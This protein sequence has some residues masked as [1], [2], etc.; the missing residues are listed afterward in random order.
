MALIQGMENANKTLSI[1]K[2]LLME[3]FWRVNSTLSKGREE[4]LSAEELRESSARRE[5]SVVVPS[6]RKQTGSCIPADARRRSF[7]RDFG[8]SAA[9]IVGNSRCEFGMG[10][11]CS[12]TRVMD[13]LSRN[14]IQPA[15]LRDAQSLSLPP[16][17]H[18]YRARQ[19]NTREDLATL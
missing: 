3:G 6:G 14:N 9:S 12:P 10:R 8:S 15:W 5:T 2:G 7:A 11:S 17:A 19:D 4:T 1:S 16:P 13:I 18:R